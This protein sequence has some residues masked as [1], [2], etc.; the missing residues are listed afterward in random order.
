MNLMAVVADWMLAKERLVGSVVVP[1]RFVNHEDEILAS[2]NLLPL[3]DVRAVSIPDVL[4]DTGATTLCLPIDIIRKLGVPKKRDVLGRTPT[5]EGSLELYRDV[6][7]DVL[8][9]SYT[10]ECIALREGATP[11]LGCLPLEAMGL[12][13][14]LAHRALRLLPE[15][16]DS[17][18]WLVY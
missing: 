6:T 5:G 16:G 10:S 8:G 3:D 17:T 12:E 18:F 2:R 4:V 1:V 11:L 7:I 9:R 13:P 14:D 15:T